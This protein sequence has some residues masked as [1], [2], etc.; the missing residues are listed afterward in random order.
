MAKTDIVQR[1]EQ[2]ET[3]DGTGD[4]VVHF[5]RNPDGPEAADVIRAL[6][7]EVVQLLEELRACRGNRAV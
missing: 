1:L 6:R 3:G 4:H 5:Y 2:V 7:R